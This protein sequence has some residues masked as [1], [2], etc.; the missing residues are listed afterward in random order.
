MNRDSRYAAGALILLSFAWGYNWVLMKEAL[1][2]AGPFDFAAWRTG[3]GAGV[4]FLI[5][6]MQR[7]LRWP[8]KFGG[9]A[10]LGLFQIAAFTALTMLALVNGDPGKISVLVYTMP[11]WAM[12]FA[13]RLLGQKPTHVHAL[14]TSAALVGV[15]CMA[16]PW[17]AGLSYSSVLYALGGAATWGFSSV[18]AT[19]LRHTGVDA[20]SM[21]AWSM[22]VGGG[23]LIALACLVPS[24]PVRWTPYFVFILLYNAVLATALAW[25]LWTYVLDRLSIVAASLGVLAVPLVGSLS[26]AIQLGERFSPIEVAGM[27]TILL[28]IGAVYRRAGMSE[29]PKFKSRVNQRRDQ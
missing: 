20:L 6:L 8:T 24:A 16:R 19:R 12:V 13:W 27:G 14:A 17:Q 26:S 1:E 10:I 23:I 7:R 11:V 4:L 5:L 29:G 9:L 25:L 21:T 22:A 18:Y 15:V 2:Y 28:S 3:I